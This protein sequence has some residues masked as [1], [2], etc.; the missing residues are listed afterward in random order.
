MLATASLLTAAVVSVPFGPDYVFRPTDRVQ[1]KITGLPVAFGEP[2]WAYDIAEDDMV[3]VD[4]YA[5]ADPKLRFSHRSWATGRTVLG[6]Q[7]DLLE[8]LTE[9]FPG[10]PLK[11]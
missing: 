6:F 5:L 11:L 3:S 7:F 1:I 9:A 4:M 10:R 8:G 2:D